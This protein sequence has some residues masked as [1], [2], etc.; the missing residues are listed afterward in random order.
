MPDNPLDS[1]KATELKLLKLY[2]EQNYIASKLIEL[3][4]CI[5]AAIDKS[6]GIKLE[7]YSLIEKGLVNK[8]IK[9][10]T[11]IAGFETNCFVSSQELNELRS[12][13][14]AQHKFIVLKGRSNREALKFSLKKILSQ[15]DVFK[16][17]VLY[18]APLSRQ[19][20]P[21][22]VDLNI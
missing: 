18:S 20:A 14:A 10:K 4:E 8:L 6:D 16:G 12:L 9:V 2:T 15:L 13:T 7:Y 3:L 19:T 11:V 21:R 17:K 1:N 5:S 22:F